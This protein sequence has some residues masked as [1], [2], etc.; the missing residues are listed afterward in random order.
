M[1]KE[2]PPTETP[3][4]FAQTTPRD[5]HPTSDIRFVIT[6]VAKL[7][8]LVER[9]IKD[10]EEQGKKVDKLN[11]QATFIKGGMAVGAI[12]IGLFGWFITSLIDGKLQ[13]ALDALSKLQP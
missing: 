6:E 9:L 11:S 8:T 3:Q 4:E 1:V 5:L 10:V 13:A 2:V 12:A 7:S